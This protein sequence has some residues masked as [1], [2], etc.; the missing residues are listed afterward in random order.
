MRTPRPGR[1]IR[2]EK[3]K[4]EGETLDGVLLFFFALCFC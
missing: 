3:E 2:R 4:G 1:D